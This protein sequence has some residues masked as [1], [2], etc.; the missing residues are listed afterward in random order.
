MHCNPTQGKTT[1][2]MTRFFLDALGA[3]SVSPSLP[4]LAKT[5]FAISSSLESLAAPPVKKK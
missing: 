5:F 3:A 4:L 2:A 1:Y